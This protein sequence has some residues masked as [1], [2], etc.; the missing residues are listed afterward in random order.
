LAAPE[1]HNSPRNDGGQDKNE[2]EKTVLNLEGGTA[3]GLPPL[4]GAAGRRSAFFAKSKNPT[5]ASLR[6]HLASYPKSRTDP[7]EPKGGYPQ[8]SDPA[9]RSQV[10]EEFR[11]VNTF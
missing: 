8:L 11:H 4:N 3:T 7:P 6:A 1:Q 2:S 10:I 5:R 9:T